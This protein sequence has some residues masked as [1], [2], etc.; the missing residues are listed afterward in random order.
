MSLE[1]PRGTGKHPIALIA[2]PAN[3]FAASTSFYAEGFGLPDVVPF[4]AV[5][6]VDQALGM[7]TFGYFTDRRG[8]RWV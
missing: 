3:R 7:G 6:D 4:I 1:I 8:P 2:I 5:P